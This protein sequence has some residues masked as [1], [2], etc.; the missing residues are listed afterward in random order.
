[1]Q[2]AALA[3]ELS[4]A[5]GLLVVS[6]PCFGLDFSA[7]AEIRS[8][9]VSARN[10][11]AAVLLFS[12]DLDEVLELSDRVVVMSEGRIAYEAPIAEADHAEI[13]RRMAGKH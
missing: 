4:G 10:A 8:R 2:R 7:A 11:G 9:I 5:V 3:R 12:E 1:V 6:N 13:G